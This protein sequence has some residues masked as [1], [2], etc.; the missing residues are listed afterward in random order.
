[1]AFGSD[2]DRDVAPL[3]AIDVT[4]LG[5]LRH[6]PTAAAAMLNSTGSTNAHEK[7]KQN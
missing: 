7:Q 1:M 2:N 3:A 5:P 6:F 4:D